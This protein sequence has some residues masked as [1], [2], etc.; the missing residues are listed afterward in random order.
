MPTYRI[1][2]RDQQRVIIGRDD[3]AAADD[4]H[5]L[6]IARTLRRACSDVCAGIELCR[7]ELFCDLILLAGERWNA[8]AMPQKGCR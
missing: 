4:E 6:T 3:F 1:Y 5:A 2:C 7:E 8:L